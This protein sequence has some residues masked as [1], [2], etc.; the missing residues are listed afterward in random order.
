MSESFRRKEQ[1]KHYWVPFREADII[2]SQRAEFGQVS[3]N[4]VFIPYGKQIQIDVAGVN[5]WLKSLNI[6][7][8]IEIKP[9]RPR[10]ED[11]QVSS[12]E[13]SK[14]GEA[15]ISF[16]GFKSKLPKPKLALFIGD[17]ETNTQAILINFSGIADYIKS[18]KTGISD[19]DF[20]S[21]YGRMVDIALKSQAIKLIIFN[22]LTT[23]K[24]N[25]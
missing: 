6:A 24:E 3:W 8:P 23:M 11:F 16:S 15:A 12:M 1:E 18:Q 22:Y 13:V 25:P 19:K 10:N 17:W 5:R 7:F 21:Q 4:P 2:S 20:N 9:Y 14:N